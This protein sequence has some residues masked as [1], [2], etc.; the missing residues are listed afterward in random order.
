MI[1]ILFKKDDYSLLYQNIKQYKNVFRFPI[2]KHSYIINDTIQMALD[3]NKK[4][5]PRISSYNKL[6]H[7]HDQLFK[8][9]RLKTMPDFKVHNDYKKV[10]EV[11]PWLELI[12]TKERLLQ[13]SEEQKNCVSSYAYRIDKAQCAIYSA[14]INNERYTIEL[15]RS[16][17][18]MNPEKW[19]IAL[20]QIESSFKTNK[21]VPK[22]LKDN[23]IHQI[24]EYNRSILNPDI[25]IN[26]D[27]KCI[28][29]TIGENNE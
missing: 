17:I 20:G 12:D 7:I 13:E 9:Y 26:I 19:G 2:Y 21:V 11:F 29:N 1:Y 18:N 8:E 10:V 4:L 16:L 14:I 28:T 6:V 3:I 27:K 15:N 23:I 5:S 25:K 22:K 24:N